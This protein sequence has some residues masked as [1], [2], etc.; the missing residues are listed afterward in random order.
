[1]REMRGRAGE[2]VVEKENQEKER[3]KG[4]CVQKGKRERSCEKLK[5]SFI[6]AWGT[7]VWT[8][9]LDSIG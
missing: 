1:V 4:V 6:G 5:I 2:G 7:H 8:V 3:K 9:W